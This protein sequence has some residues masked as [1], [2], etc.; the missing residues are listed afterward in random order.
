MMDGN[1]SELQRRRERY[2]HISRPTNAVETTH[3]WM[4]KDEARRREY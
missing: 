1:T 3:G 4:N 2:A